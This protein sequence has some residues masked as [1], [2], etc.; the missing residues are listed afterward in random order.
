MGNSTS[1]HVALDGHRYDTH[2]V[3]SLHRTPCHRPSLGVLPG[4]IFASA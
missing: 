2:G 1:F 4:A 3:H